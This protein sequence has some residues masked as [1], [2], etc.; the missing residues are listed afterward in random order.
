MRTILFIAFCCKIVFYVQEERYLAAIEKKSA[1]GRSG[2][3]KTPECL[4]V[5]TKLTIFKDQACEV[6]KR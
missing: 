2:V 5:V 1:D 4:R 6:R 3:Q